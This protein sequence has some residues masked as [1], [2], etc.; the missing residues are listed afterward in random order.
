[1]PSRILRS[2]LNLAGSVRSSLTRIHRPIKLAILQ[3]GIVG[4]IST[5]TDETG[6]AGSSVTLMWGRLTTASCDRLRGCSGSEM[7]LSR[8]TVSSAERRKYRRFPARRI[9]PLPRRNH[10]PLPQAHSQ[11][12]EVAQTGLATISRPAWEWPPPRG[13]S[14]WR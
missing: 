12:G 11:A 6:K 8:S 10:P 9:A 4:V 7:L 1:V 2:T 14:D 3:C 5:S 13:P